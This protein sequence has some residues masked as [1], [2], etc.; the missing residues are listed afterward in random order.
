M[1]PK[2]LRTLLQ[3]DAII[4]LLASRHKIEPPKSTM[5][6]PFS[7]PTTPI[8][9]DCR[10][11]I[12]FINVMP[13]LKP[14]YFYMIAFKLKEIHLKRARS[15]QTIVVPNE[16]PHNFADRLIEFQGVDSLKGKS[17]VMFQFY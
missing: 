14:S 8:S 5:A 13:V 12:E 7:I 15:P 4:A 11:E 17:K 3:G 6:I 10:T 2:V 16:E 1:S 9:I